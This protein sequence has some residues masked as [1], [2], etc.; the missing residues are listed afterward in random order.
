MLRSESWDFM[1][2][3]PSL[4]CWSAVE[5]ERQFKLDINQFSK[6]WN[7]LTST[8][9]FSNANPGF[10]NSGKFIGFPSTLTVIHF[11]QS[12]KNIFRESV[13]CFNSGFTEWSHHGIMLAVDILSIR[14]LPKVIFTLFITVHNFL[15]SQFILE[16]FTWARPQLNGGDPGPCALKQFGVTS[17]Y[18]SD[19]RHLLLHMALPPDGI[20]DSPGS[21]KLAVQYHLM[22]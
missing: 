20:H 14:F 10:L 17:R 4:N 9:R 16:I 6:G 3:S 5:W 1:K 7:C 12:N 8:Q 2:A 22:G 11:P 13:R 18:R 21:R 19:L 15:L